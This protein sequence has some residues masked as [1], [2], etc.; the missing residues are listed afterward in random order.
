MKQENTQTTVVTE[1]VDYKDKYVRLLA[2]MDNLRKNSAKQISSAATLANEKM[3]KEMLPCLDAM[4]IAVKN[5]VD[6]DNGYE[7]L[8]KQL[9]DILAKFGVQILEVK[10]NDTFDDATMNAILSVPSQSEEQQHNTVSCVIKKGYAL[11]GSVIRYA[12]V[13]VYSAA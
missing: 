9:L 13:I 1:E 11:N 7:M 2:D 12:D 6:G 4:D 8:R 5:A 3:V 10:E